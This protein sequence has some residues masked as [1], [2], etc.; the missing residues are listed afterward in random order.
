MICVCVCVSAG[1][2]SVLW[3]MAG[4]GQVSSS[5]DKLINRGQDPAG[6]LAVKFGNLK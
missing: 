1:G 2:M 5:Y 6:W 3:W 4:V